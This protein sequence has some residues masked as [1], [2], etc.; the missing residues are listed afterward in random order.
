MNHPQSARRRIRTLLAAG[1]CAGM[2]G[3]LSA[4]APVGNAVGDT[5]E[6][7]PRVPVDATDRGDLIVGLVGSVEG[8]ANGTDKTVLDALTRSG[9]GTSYASVSSVTSPD[10]AMQDGVRDYVARMADAILI[11]GITVT[12]GNAAGWDE[13]LNEA[14]Q[15]G[16]PVVL[17]DPIHAPADRTLYAAA[18]LTDPADTGGKQPTPIDDALMDIIDDLP[19]AR[20][21]PVTTAVQ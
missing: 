3:T 18:F 6:H 16:L 9:I 14:R 4:C 13:A 21:M 20:R 15:A 11:S 1:L 7:A 19:H 17:I 12:T 10:A 5:Q 8:A 2:A